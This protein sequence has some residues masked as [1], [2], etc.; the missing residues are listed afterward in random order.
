MGTGA[1]G[2]TPAVTAP[3][4]VVECTVPWRFSCREHRLARYSVLA[5]IRERLAIPQRAARWGA[6]I[7]APARFWGGSRIDR[8]ASTDRLSLGRRRPWWRNATGRLR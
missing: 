2:L 4:S 7:A 5:S 1:I 8:F 6:G 3:V